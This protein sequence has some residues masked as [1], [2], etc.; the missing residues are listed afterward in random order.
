MPPDRASDN[1]REES[2]PAD[3]HWDP[4][5][6]LGW[7]L[8]PIADGSPTA[9]PKRTTAPARRPH[10]APKTALVKAAPEKTTPER[11]APASAAPASLPEQNTL[12]GMVVS[13]VFIFL[14]MR[15]SFL[16][17]YLASKIGV[18]LF[19]LVLTGSIS[20]IALLRGSTWRVCTQSRVFWFWTGFAA[21]LAIGIPFSFW[22]GGSFGIVFPFLKDSFLC[23][24]LIS[25]IVADL[26]M[27]RRLF[28]TLGWASFLFI[29]IALVSHGDSGGRLVLPWSG[30]VGNSN[31]L[32]GHLLF[33]LPL[34]L[35]AAFWSQRNGFVRLALLAMLPLALYL[36]LKTGS[37][38]A[39]VGL[40]VTLVFMFLT[41]SAKVRVGFLLAVPVLGALLAVIVPQST[42]TRL[43][44]MS[45][46][47]NQSSEAA[48]SYKARQQLLIKSL[49]IT[50][51]H[52]LLGTGAGQFGSFEGEKSIK[53]GHAHNNWQETHNSF[54]EISSEDGIPA[55]LCFIGGT[56][57]TLFL[58]GKTRKMSK[59]HEEL[60]DVALAAQLLWVGLIGFCGCIFF[61]NFGYKM[62]LPIMAG[63]ALALHNI[64]SRYVAAQQSSESESLS[65]P[66]AAFAT[67]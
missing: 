62:Y 28:L 58:L 26:P 57:G 42:F 37:R 65:E 31:D 56:I 55:A 21:L 12:P 44:N 45:D 15:M 18:N 34:L 27:L 25:G 38:G 13:F 16:H 11:T 10:T 4:K 49:D 43:F 39:F 33:V 47:G 29:I 63:L 54:T 3:R 61:L 1:P 20:Y 51:H 8:P 32:G 2:A 7:D 46:Q 36:M 48:E 17:E 24:P 35:V 14:F 67:R 50:L 5:R 60:A 6:P 23:I 19:L 40:A 59:R 30:S 53:E 52:P 64:A 22:P 41:G 9:L 66:T